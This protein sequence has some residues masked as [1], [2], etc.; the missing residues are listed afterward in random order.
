MLYCVHA[1]APCIEQAFNKQ[2]KKKEKK[3]TAQNEHISTLKSRVYW[4]STTIKLQGGV[5]KEAE[6]ND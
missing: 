1:P 6:L 5:K 4:S 3:K 2:V